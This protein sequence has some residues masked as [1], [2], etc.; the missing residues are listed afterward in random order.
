MTFTNSLRRQNTCVP[1]AILLVLGTL[2]MRAQEGLRGEYFNNVNLEGTP[3]IRVDP[4]INFDWQQG[5]PITNVG[6]E[7]FS[8]RWTGQVVPLYSEL[9]TF[10]AT[11]DDGARLWVNGERL[12]NGWVPRLPT[13]DTGTILLKAG[14]PYTIQ[15]EFFDLTVDALVSLS[16]SSLS[17]AYQIIPQSQLRVPPPG[18]NRPP[19]TPIFIAPSA[20]NLT[21]DAA[22]PLLRTDAFSDPDTGDIHAC[23]DWEIWA[24]DGTERVWYASCTN[25]TNLLSVQLS[26]GVFEN[27]HSNRT[28]LALHREYVLRVR[29]SDGSGDPETEWSNRAER[30]FNTARPLSTIIQPGAAWR[31]R[32]NSVDQGTAWRATNFNDSLWPVGRAQFGFGDG[33]EIT[34]TCCS[35]GPRPITTYFRHAFVLTN[36][37]LITNLTGYLLRDDGGVVYLNGAEVFRSNLDQGISI[38]YSTLAANAT[39]ADELY[40]FHPFNVPVR[41]LRVGTNIVAVEVHQSSTTSSDLSFDFELVAEVTTFPAPLRIACDTLDC[42]VL[43]WDDPEVVLE[44]SASATGPWSAMSPPVESPYRLCDV[45]ASNFY[46]LRRR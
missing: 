37:S 21:L 34:P 23:S 4:Q 26:D 6:P 2:T 28:T 35:S 20:T 30:P 19:N 5:S 46:R 29:H 27:S 1:F 31:Y 9:Y 18:Q 45:K 44:Y 22:N 41:N 43:S 7:R 14:R 16:W 10:Y 39:A 17:Q 36:T 38:L 32:D 8:V 40:F 11:S 13:T 42:I 24:A 25:A 12:I 15:F 3:I 33:D